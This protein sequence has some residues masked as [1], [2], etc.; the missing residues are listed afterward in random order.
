MYPGYGRFRFLVDIISIGNRLKDGRCGF[1]IP[2]EAKQ[3]LLYKTLTP[4]V[5]SNLSRIQLVPGLFSG[6]ETTAT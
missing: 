3:F 1:R 6:T 5:E 4:A 2:V